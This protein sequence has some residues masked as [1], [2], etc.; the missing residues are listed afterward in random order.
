M[1][2]KLLTSPAS[3]EDMER[4]AS[5]GALTCRG[6]ADKG[7]MPDEVIEILIDNVKKYKIPGVRFIRWGEPTLHK[8]YLEVAAIKRGT[9]YGA[10]S[11]IKSGSTNEILDK[12][13]EQGLEQVIKDKF[14]Q[15]A[16]DLEN[17]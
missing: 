3:I 1:N 4:F 6:N 9:A 15:L 8:R 17:I 13:D 2:V 10:E 5:L 16:K 12:L 14:V 7:F 11:V